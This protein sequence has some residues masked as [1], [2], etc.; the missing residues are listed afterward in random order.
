MKFTNKVRDE[1]KKNFLLLQT[2]KFLSESE[3]ITAEKLKKKFGFPKS[4]LYKFLGKLEEENLIIRDG[5]QEGENNHSL[6][7]YRSTDNLNE[8]LFFIKRD[9]MEFLKKF[10]KNSIENDVS[11]EIMRDVIAIFK[12][13]IMPNIITQTKEYFDQ[14]KSQ[15]D[16]NTNFF[17]NLEEYMYDHVKSII[18]YPFLRALI[19]DSPE[20]SK[21][22]EHT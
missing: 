17:R 5:K 12:Y 2:L 20:K 4:T 15:K 6:I 14:L 19:S 16:I 8:F 21:V 3:S 11:L 18:E 7:N 10:C 9:I 22:R 13:N 1:L